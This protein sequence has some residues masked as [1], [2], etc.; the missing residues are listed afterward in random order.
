VRQALNTITEGDEFNL[1][2]EDGRM[3]EE[4]KEATTRLKM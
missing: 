4:T 1:T 2:G 3:M